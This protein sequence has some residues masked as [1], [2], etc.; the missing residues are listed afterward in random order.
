MFSPLQIHAG[1]EIVHSVPLSVAFYLLSF[2][3]GILS[4]L[5]LVANF[6]KKIYYIMFF[7]VITVVINIF[8]ESMLLYRPGIASVF[9]AKVQQLARVMRRPLLL[10]LAI[11]AYKPKYVDKKWWVALLYLPIIPPLL[12]FV[13][14]ETDIKSF[15]ICTLR[16]I[17]LFLYTSLSVFFLFKRAIHQE[18]ANERIFQ[19]IVVLCLLLSAFSSP[20]E[21]LFIRLFPTSSKPSNIKDYL[22]LFFS[23]ATMLATFWSVKDSGTIRLIEGMSR[24]DLLRKGRKN[25]VYSFI[26]LM[27]II[28]SAIYYGHSLYERNLAYREI[29]PYCFFVCLLGAMIG[30]FKKLSIS[31]SAKDLLLSFSVG[32]F[33]DLVVNNVS[34]QYLFPIWF[35]IVFFMLLFVL[36][37]NPFAIVT[38]GLITLAASTM[39]LMNLPTPSAISMRMADYSLG[40]LLFGLISIAAFLLNMAFTKRL[41]AYQEQIRL[42]DLVTEISLSFTN[43]SAKDVD[44]SIDRLL[45]LAAHTF[46]ME[47]AVIW[48]VDSTGLSAW[49][50]NEWYKEG[51]QPAKP[52]FP[53]VYIPHF[54]DFYHVLSQNK[55]LELSSDYFETYYRTQP[56]NPY[57]H[58]EVHSVLCIPL[59]ADGSSSGFLRRLADSAKEG[60]ATR[61]LYT[62]AVENESSAPV[63]AGFIGFT[64]REP[65][66]KWSETQRYL[67]R[68]FASTLLH[69]AVKAQSERTMY[70]MAFFDQ[71]TSL[72]NRFYLEDA[73]EQMIK[74]AEQTSSML[75]VALIDLDSF[76]DVNDSFGH[77]VGDEVLK[78]VSKRLLEH[79]V[80]QE[81]LVRFGGDE[82]IILLKG[83]QN[84]ESVINRITGIMRAFA[85]PIKIG[86]QSF[87]IT[88]SAG[89]SIYPK[90]GKTSDTLIKHADMTMY[91]SKAKGKNR[92]GLC[93][94]QLKQE[95]ADETYLMNR[96]NT[97]IE[98]NQLSLNYQPVVRLSDHAI[99]GYEALCRWHLPERGWV[100]PSVFIPLAERSSLINQIGA[101]VLETACRQTKR[102]HDGGGKKLPVSVNFSMRQ[103]QEADLADTVVN[104]LEQC[105]LDAKYLVIEITESTENRQEKT[106][107]NLVTDF[108]NHGISIALDDFGM[109]Y[110]SL[111]RLR[112][113]P[114]SKLKIDMQFIRRITLDNKDRGLTQTIIQLAKNL[115]ISVVA[116]GVETQEQLDILKDWGCD[117]VQGYFFYRPLTT[118]QMESLLLEPRPFVPD[119]TE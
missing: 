116:E 45:E 78:T 70:S 85:Q 28:N 90:D 88:A 97:A 84:E 36:L 58:L 72:P 47:R 56:I 31:D 51:I 8:V 13:L 71:L 21:I 81:T 103:F 25:Q 83:V 107:E 23:T 63:M 93:T 80:A 30:I 92:F 74:S 118:P 39:R 49:L 19:L 17:V 1:C 48:L 53:P 100:P 59:M 44:K 94:E 52:I 109:Q 86:A 113:L 101:W 4:Y 98:N 82:F 15:H 9:W 34:L 67:L 38:I 57:T 29:L 40:I 68:V 41:R 3:L 77:N 6:N 12:H 62:G 106:I 114:F 89:V 61:D 119:K 35:F 112:V 43:I 32:L 50:T 108:A 54:M 64:S 66:K 105:K 5:L 115:N 73:L 75:A 26:S 79:L 111:N 24:H 76:K 42:Q 95:I 20:A 46:G 10:H 2:A 16:E 60:S 110:S 22:L 65:N 96:L 33:I 55:I 27:F 91:V 18:R 102:W 14:L 99:V 7:L 104:I 87:Y 11:M 69:I 37:S 117:E